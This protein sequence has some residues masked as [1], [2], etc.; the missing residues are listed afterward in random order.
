VLEI[1]EPASA[2]LFLDSDTVQAK[3]ADLRPE[4]ARKLIA[5]VY[6]GGARRDLVA[7]EIEYMLGIMVGRPPANG[8]LAHSLMLCKSAC[9]GPKRLERGIGGIAA[10]CGQMRQTLPCPDA[11]DGL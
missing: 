3:R 2:I 6:L 1:P 9:H 8:L 11:R 7:R 10:R 5:P 4:V